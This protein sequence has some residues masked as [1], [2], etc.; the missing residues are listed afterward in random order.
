MELQ[1]LIENVVYKKDFLAEHGLSMLVKKEDKAVLVDTGQS[2]NFIIN[3]GLMGINL[4]DINKVILTHGHYDHVGGLKDLMDENKDVR[5][6]ASHKILNRKYALRK[7]GTID[8]IGFDLSIYEK[9]KE[10]FVLIHEDTE[11]EK[12]FF[13]VTSIDEKYNNDFTTKNF[14]VEK[15]N[16]KIKDSFLD[17]IFFVVKEGDCINI[18]TGCS[19]LG[20]L[21]ILYT[22]ESKFKG[23][24]I[25]S[26]I[27]GFHLKGMIEEDVVNILEAMKDYDIQYIYTGHCT[28]I[29]EYGIMKNF[30]RQGIL[31]D[32]EFVYNFVK[33]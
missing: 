16:T 4:K 33:I 19:H 13:V 8:E 29:D 2:G 31:F 6:Y 32:Y 3:F 24:R 30:R 22:A 20:I 1:V 14:L 5:I 11:V 26:L 9:N 17:E 15:D 25:K 12:D 10:N 18:I 27:G 7:N 28:G 23:Y 21:N